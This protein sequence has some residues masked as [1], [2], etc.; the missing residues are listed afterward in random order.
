MALPLIQPF[1]ND[2]PMRIV[3]RK[4]QRGPQIPRWQKVPLAALAVRMKATASNAR[5]A[6]AESVR[7][8]K[9]DTLIGWHRAIVRRKWTYKQGRKPGRPPID[10]DLEGW[11]LQV[12]RDNPTLG[13]DKL[14]GEMRKL[15]FDVGA[16]TIRTVLLRHGVPPAPERSRQ[17]SS[18]RTFLN[19]YKEQFIACD[20]FT[21]ETLTLHTL[22]CLFFIEHGTRQ[23]YFA[24]CT[25]HPDNAWITQ[26]A[27]QMTWEFEDRELPMKYLIRDHDTRF[28]QSFD[29]VFEAAG[30]EIVN[31]PYQAPNANAFAERWVRSVREECLD[32]LIVLNERHLRRVMTEYVAYFNERRP[33]QGLE[34][35]S[36]L[37][38]E[39]VSIDGPIRCRHV[40]GGIIRDYYRE[41]A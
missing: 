31:I 1:L 18:W 8:F 15:G 34:Q 28:T 4:Q 10:S 39:S 33:H 20:F 17:G 24:G 7:L 41:A 22:Y 12:A 30:I 26:Q 38:L 16:T 5:E 40:L 19:H 3:E 35:D 29:T 27:R 13:Y 11:V 36:P 9:P 14:E 21:V 32:H 6:L 2:S 23:V 37:G 25:A